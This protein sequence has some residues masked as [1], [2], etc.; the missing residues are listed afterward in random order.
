V[1]RGGASGIEAGFDLYDDELPQQERVR[2]KP[3]RI[4]EATT[5][6]ALGLLDRLRED[7]DVPS[8][9]WVHY[10]DP[11]GPY[12][13]PVG[14]RRRY[15]DAERKRPDGRR[16]LPSTWDQSGIGAIPAYQLIGTQN[17]AAF[18]R[19]GYNGEVR[20]VDEAIGGLLDGLRARGLIDQ[21]ILVFSADH[22]EGLGEN[23]YWFAHG[24]H[25]G[26]PLVHVPLMIRLPGRPAARRS[27][28]ASL[29]D[30]V[31]TVASALDLDLPFVP[32]GRDLLADG[33]ESDSA[34]VYLSTLGESTVL[35]LGLISDGYKYLVSLGNEVP[36]EQLFRVGDER[37]DLSA[38]EP[39]IRARLAR[40]LSVLRA[41][42]E[43]PED[44]P[45]R[46]ITPEERDALQA[47][48]YLERDGQTDTATLRRPDAKLG[49]A[50]RSED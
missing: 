17:E 8:L 39:G 37:E 28:V 2:A 44:Q 40:R 10:Q 18:Y 45:P 34:S 9:L 26:D 38:R 21:A 50:R 22:G 49:G 29:L 4:A 42:I 43:F 33:A 19:A 46:P 36:D 25:L 48:G 11:H 23:D 27:D 32:R 41:G 12:T 7:R 13:P 3:E 31:P 14:Y 5:R 6:A 47:L 30:I 15:L 16:R 20:Y 1:L 24:E 35:S